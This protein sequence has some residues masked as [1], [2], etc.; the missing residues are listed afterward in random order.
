MSVEEEKLGY[1]SLSSSL[2]LSLS[3]S[4]APSPF[5]KAESYCCLPIGTSPCLAFN[6]YHAPTVPLQRDPVVSSP[7][8]SQH[9]S[10]PSNSYGH[11]L[12]SSTSEVL[13]LGVV[14]LLLC[15]SLSEKNIHPHQTEIN[16]PS[17]IP[18]C[19]LD[20]V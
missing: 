16:P 18:Y 1:L 17:I 9:S 12:F 10:F 4:P 3:L 7:P 14:F 5:P 20:H 2:S 11:S 13:C 15:Q 6:Q 19:P 8:G